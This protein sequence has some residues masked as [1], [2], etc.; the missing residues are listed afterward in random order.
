LCSLNPKYKGRTYIGFTVDPNRRIKQ[1]NRGKDAGG[2]RKT[3]NKGPWEMVL[4]THGFPNEI[5]ALR[6]EWAWQNPGSSRRLKHLEAKTRKEKLFD[7]NLRILSE[8]LRLGP[9]NR[10]PLTVRWLKP[11]YERSFSV[12]K[13]PPNHMPLAHG[14]I[15]CLK[16]KPPKPGELE[17]SFE[18]DV[19]PTICNL[20]S[21]VVAD[22]TKA[23]CLNNDCDFVCHLSCLSRR[24]LADSPSELIP[25][26]GVCPVCEVELL[27][28]DVIR[29]KKGCF[30]D[31]NK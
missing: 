6:F 25:I 26:S 2:A 4:I 24:F 27:W 18:E 5:S 30:Q 13:Q 21:S 8:M 1:H 15:K 10:L 7:Y 3:S 9:W 12:D 11:E 31:A 29:K 19:R 17:F 22:S 14:P 23:D 16:K 28:G 20:C